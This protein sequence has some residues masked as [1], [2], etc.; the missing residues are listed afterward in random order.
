MKSNLLIFVAAYALAACNSN[1]SQRKLPKVVNIE[2]LKGTT[3]VPTL[4]TQILYRK[5]VIYAPTF[6]Y[7]WD[8][9]KDELGEPIEISYRNFRDFRQINSST[10]HLE[11]L[12]PSEYTTEVDVSNGAIVARA[13]FNKSLPFAVKFQRLDNV[14]PFDRDIVSVFGMQRYDENIAQHAEILYYDDDDH[15]V[16]KLK[17]RDTAHEIILA[18]GLAGI[19][20]LLDVVRETNDLIQK[21]KHEKIQKNLAWKYVIN[22]E[23]KFAIPVIQF[24]IEANFKTIAGQTFWTTTRK[25]YV[26]QAYQRTGL[27]LDEYGAIVESEATV[28]T[29]S[30]SFPPQPES[31][32]NMLFNRT[33]YVIIKH[34]DK[35]NPYFV[36]KVFNSELLTKSE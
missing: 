32:K 7:A 10:T 8:K 30:A 34:T 31:P 35:I 6:L 26:E 22:T 23:D 5:N 18:K 9:V 14:V 4:E 24:N 28:V 25:H 19:N 16:L 20:T 21:G 12:T 11:S 17:P 36:M 29:D 33:F 3:F 2:E 1:D 13:F 15:F 27:I